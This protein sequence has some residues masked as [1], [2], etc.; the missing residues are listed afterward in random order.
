[1]SKIKTKEDC[2]DIYLGKKFVLSECSGHG[3]VTLYAVPVTV[4][5]NEISYAEFL[6]IFSQGYCD[7]NGYE[8]LD[9]IIDI[10]EYHTSVKF[11]CSINRL[12]EEEYDILDDLITEKLKFML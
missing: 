12:S 3:Y 4:V 1:M 2:K 11:G 5:Y 7:Q 10:I 9:K 6:V 8:S